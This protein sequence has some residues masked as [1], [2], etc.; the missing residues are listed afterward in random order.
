MSTNCNTDAEL[1]LSSNSESAITIVGTGAVSKSA[2]QEP[3]NISK[4]ESA[5][6]VSGDP[7]ALVPTSGRGQGT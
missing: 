7:P 1:D 5:K 3:V 6:A 4:S 2:G